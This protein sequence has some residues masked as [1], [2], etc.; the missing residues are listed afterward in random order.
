MSNLKL[1]F[2][3]GSRAAENHTHGIIIITTMKREVIVVLVKEEIYIR[4][5]IQQHVLCESMNIYQRTSECCFVLRAAQFH[6]M[7]SGQLR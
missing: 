3:Q 1:L 5:H 4:V 6:L 2:I 7:C